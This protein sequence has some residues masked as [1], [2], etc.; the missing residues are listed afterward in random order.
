[1]RTESV[2][3]REDEQGTGAGLRISGGKRDNKLAGDSD[4]Q[5]VKYEFEVLED[6]R[7]VI[8]VAELRATRGRM[9]L[10]PV[11]RLVKLVP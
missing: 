3:A 8:L 9:W 2:A 5:A 6:V 7:D 10:E 1:M 11:A 4:W